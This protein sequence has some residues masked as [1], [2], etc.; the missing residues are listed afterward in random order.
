M[1]F[2]MKIQAWRHLKTI[3]RHKWMVLKGCFKL[4]M[5]KQGLFHDLSKYSPTE[6]IPGALYYQ[7]F[8]SPCNSEREA[9]GY[10]KAWLHHKG[11][12]KHHYEYW[13]DYA[14]TEGRGMFPAPIPVRYVVEMFVDR[15]AASKIYNGEN[16]TDQSPLDYYNGGKKHMMIHEDSRKLLEGL[17]KMLAKEGEKK[18]FRYIKYRIVKNKHFYR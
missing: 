9:L 3:T 15:V 17:L 4:G 13:I 14:A 16:Y 6:F 10:Y 2:N 7:G 1:D 11:R 18:T 12:N 8:R 5:Y